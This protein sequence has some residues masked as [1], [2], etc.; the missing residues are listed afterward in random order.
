[1][2]EFMAWRWAVRQWRWPEKGRW[3]ARLT[4]RQAA[5]AALSLTGSRTVRSPKSATRVQAPA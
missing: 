4:H 5:V 3:L 1:M 2:M